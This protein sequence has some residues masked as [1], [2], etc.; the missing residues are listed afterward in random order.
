MKLLVFGGTIFLGRHVVEAARTAG[1]EVTLFNRG[2]SNPDLF[3]GVETLTGDRDGGLAALEGRRWDAVVDTCG[4]V[5]RI[6]RASAELLAGAV[7]RYVFVS[8]LS[9]YASPMPAGAD[10]TAPVAR[11]DDETVE[12]VTGESYGPLKVLCEE[13]ADAA[14]PGRTISLRAG[15]IVGPHDPTGRFTYWPV[16]VARGG[17][18]L[19][20]EGPDTEV[21]FIDVRDL[22]AWTLHLIETGAAGPFNAIGPVLGFGDLLAAC[23]EAGGSDARVHWASSIVLEKHAVAP[24]VGLPLWVTAPDRGLLQADRRRAVQH[25]LTCRPVGE[26]V[27]DT[28]AWTR[29]WPE[30]TKLP[31]G[32]DAEK[33]AEVLADIGV[34]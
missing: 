24:W 7:D 27:A 11:M 18:V 15:L 29:T 20:P 25:G 33:E 12:K 30:G 1:H 34:S 8:S 16:R 17:D 10:E 5:P 13:A 28:L 21:Q 2:R 31:V 26:T 9:A 4:Y 23:S 32:I 22:A 3:P 19:A 14:V 6:V